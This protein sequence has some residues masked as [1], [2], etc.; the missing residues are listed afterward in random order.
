MRLK[1]LE[2]VEGPANHLALYGRMDAALDTQPYSGTTTTCEA[3]WMGVPVLTLLG[4]VMVE[5]QSA[6]VLAGAGLGAAIARNEADWL[7]RARLLAAK[8]VRSRQDRL[9]LR[10]WVAASPLADTAALVGALEQLYRALWQR[11]PLAW[12]L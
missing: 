8:G 5:R 4:E 7:A 9:A 6:A 10:E 12:R 3:L 1:L 2:W 11:R